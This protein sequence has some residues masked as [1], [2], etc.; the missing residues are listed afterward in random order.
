METHT[1]S[2][3][4]NESTGRLAGALLVALAVTSVLTM[5]HHPTAHGHGAG[6]ILASLAQVARLNALV[7]GGLIA[8]MLAVLL[9]LAEF[10][11]RQVRHVGLARSGMLLYALGAGALTL[12]GLING[13]AVPSLAAGVGAGHDAVAFGPVLHF[14]WGLNQAAAGFGSIAFALAIALW[15][16]DLVRRSGLARWVGA[17]GVGAG[18]LVTVAV[19]S[20]ALSLDVRGFGAVVA[21]L[22]LWQ[23]G[24]G[25]LLWRHGRAAA[26]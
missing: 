24:A 6:E 3:Q 14:A 23:A 19:G 22:A 26:P 1:R 5:T 9:L 12:A 15:S 21:A 10:A 25:V 8:L 18:A 7:H 13:F 16:I 2:T 17:Y 11:G 4:G 20:G